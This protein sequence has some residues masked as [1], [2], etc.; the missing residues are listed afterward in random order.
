MAKDSLMSKTKNAELK[1]TGS[2][3]SGQFG[4]DHLARTKNK[5]SRDIK[6]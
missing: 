6:R 2:T 1:M 4:S 5:P 3:T